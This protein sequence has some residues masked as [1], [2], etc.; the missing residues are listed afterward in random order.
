MRSRD[1]KPE[2][3]RSDHVVA[4]CLLGL[5]ALA[6]LGLVIVAGEIFFFPQSLP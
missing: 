2:A 4:L 1:P 5:L 3:V 6:M